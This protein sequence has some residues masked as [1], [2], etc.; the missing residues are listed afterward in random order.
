MS[1]K[2][3]ELLSEK[4]PNRVAASAEIVNLRAILALPK[5][6]EYYL[7]DLHGEHEAFVHMI[8]SGSGVIRSKIDELFSD[9]MDEEG[10]DRLSSL[11]YNARAEIKRVKKDPSIDFSKWC[12]EN[13]FRLIMI[14]Q[15]CANKYTRSKVRKRLPKYWAYSMDE[16]LH[17]EDEANKG[18]YY[19]QIIRSVVD[20][21]MAERYIE[22]LTASISSL[23]VDRLHIIGD[24]Y[25]RGA[26]PDY[27]M[28]FLMDYHD[29]DLQ[30]GN[31]DIVWIGAAAGNWAC[32][33]NILRM[34][35]SYNNFDMLE[36]GYGINLRPLTSFANR[37]YADDPCTHFMPKIFD[38][39]KFDPV[40][41]ET[42]AKMH[43]AIAIMQFKVEGQLIQAHPEY[44][45]N[46]R[47]LLDKIDFEKGR[48][49]VEGVEYEMRDM[50]L[51]TIDPNDPYRLSDEEQRVIENLTASIKRSKQLQRHIRFMFSHGAMYKVCNGQ[52][53]YHGCIPMNADGTFQAWQVEGEEL[54]GK[55]LFDYLDREV[56]RQYFESA[57]NDMGGMDGSL[58]WYMWLG[59]DS[60]LFGK[61]KMTTFERLFVEDK[62][63]HHEPVIPYYALRDDP[64]ICKKILREF[65]ADPEEGH[66]LS[67]HVPVK[68]KDGESPIKGDGK[69][70][71]IDGGISK[72]Y[73]KKTGIAGYTL[74]SNSRFMALAEHKPYEPLD[75]EG[76]QVFHHPKLFTVETF[77]KRQLVQDTDQKHQLQA[78]IDDLELLIDAFKRGHIKETYQI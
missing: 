8:K 57:N 29:V 32:I 22:T 30:W 15:S 27:I 17:A 24:V 34:N 43:K 72:A 40:S 38:R 58:M 75:K 11:I 45:L 31:H 4:Y 61:T 46:H 33:A 63:T 52:L 56:R 14:C 9:E 55:E 69:V 37:V 53:L 6:T 48:V 26:H 5:G 51:P 1:K 21:G 16:L 39:N 67:G 18:N 12:Y 49:N 66:I 60:P 23:A 71:V 78:A 59:A 77:S 73:Q 20:T 62:T 41:K 47:L 25:D 13:I 54:R 42:A 68:I 36:V 3:L 19:S 35:I 10:R 74:I 50:N 7:S 64:E 28:D 44:K 70:F 76:N 65:G 2:F